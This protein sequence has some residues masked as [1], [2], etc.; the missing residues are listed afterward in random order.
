LTKELFL[1]MEKVGR[2]HFLA[3]SSNFSEK[4]PFSVERR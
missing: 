4:F 2:D 3:I 1:D